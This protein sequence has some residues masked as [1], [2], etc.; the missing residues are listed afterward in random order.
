MKT[1]YLDIETNYTGKFP[2]GDQRLFKDFANHRLTVLGIRVM[3][4][5]VD[6]VIQLVGDEITREKM[7]ELLNGVGLLVTYNGRSVPDAV[8]G[9]IGF[10]FPVIAAQLGVTLDRMFKHRDLAPLCWKHGLYGGLKKVE[11]SL[12]IKRQL[13]GKDGKWATEVWR[14]YQKNKDKSCLVE[15]LAYNREDVEMLFQVEQALEG[16]TKRHGA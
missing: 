16:R 14:R 6:Q 13:P 9:Y 5:G 3:G 15:L 11:A 1:A 4:E 10:D 7:L 12:G 2:E 8:K